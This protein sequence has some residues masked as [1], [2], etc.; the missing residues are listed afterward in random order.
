MKTSDYLIGL[1]LVALGL[2]FLFDNFGVIEFDFGRLW[3]VIVILVGVGFW[4][5]FYKNRDEFGLIIPGTILVVYGLLFWIS[6]IFNMSIGNGLWPVFIL[7]PGLGFLLIYLIAKRDP[8]FLIPG[9]ILTG[10]AVLFFLIFN[11]IFS[12]WPLFLI[13]I[14]AYLVY[15]YL[16]SSKESQ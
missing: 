14:G 11:N 1:A 4:I 10:L 16:R 2:L 13:I 6:I 8:G 7:G 5:G 3:P 9:A 15:T 12:Y